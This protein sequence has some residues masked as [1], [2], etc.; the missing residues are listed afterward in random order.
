MVPLRE[1][2]EIR[3]RML[4]NGDWKRTNILTAHRW[5]RLQKPMCQW[6][7]R[8]AH[9]RREPSLNPQRASVTLPRQCMK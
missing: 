2:L 9:W 1:Y 7:H 6:S 4:D 3:K 8:W 5:S